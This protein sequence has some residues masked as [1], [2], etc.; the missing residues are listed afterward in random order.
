[1]NPFGFGANATRTLSHDGSG[2]P[3]GDTM[4]AGMNTMMNNGRE[5]FAAL[6]DEAFGSSDMMEGSVIKGKVMAIE[7]DMAG[8]DVGLKRSE[9]RRGGKEC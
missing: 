6:L 7:K 5:D 2:R 8:I 4:S 9:E 3:D 1:M